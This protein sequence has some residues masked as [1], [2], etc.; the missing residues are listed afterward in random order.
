MGLVCNDIF[1][2]VIRVM[3]EGNLDNGLNQ[4]LISLI[5]KI[6]HL[7][8]IKHFRPIAVCMVMYKIV[9]KLISNRVKSI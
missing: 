2:E 5:P 6:S 8:N 4:T 1:D 9:A 7:F 3:Q